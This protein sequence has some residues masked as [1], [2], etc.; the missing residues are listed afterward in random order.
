MYWFNKDEL[1]YYNRNQAGYCYCDIIVKPQDL[2]LQAFMP[3]V[4]S[5]VAYTIKAYTPDGVT[6]LLDLAPF[7]KGLFAIDNTGRT[8]CTFELQ[9]FPSS[10]CNEC[11]LVRFTVTDLVGGVN[12]VLFDRYTQ[13]YCIKDCCTI[14]GDLTAS[15]DFEQETFTFSNGATSYIDECGKPIVRIESTFPCIDKYT[16]D[17]YGAP[18]VKIK[19]INNDA[20]DNVPYRK[21]SNHYALWKRLPREINTT[22]ALNCITQKTE[23]AKLYMLQSSQPVPMWKMEELENMLSS[24]NILVNGVQY[25]LQ[26][27]TPFE[28]I[29]PY[30]INAVR[31]FYRF[32]I[33]L[34]SCRV[35]QIFGCAPICKVSNNLKY[36]PIT[37]EPSYFYDPNGVL[38]AN[39]TDEFITYLLSL[40][41]VD[42]VQD[43]SYAYLAF[44]YNTVL[45][46]ETTSGYIPSFF[47]INGRG[48][49][50]KVFTTDEVIDLN[51]GCA[52]A[53]IGVITDQ[54]GACPAA[55][56][57]T[58]AD[59]AQSQLTDTVYPI[60]QW[61]IEPGAMTTLS[62]NWVRLYF[63]ARN[64]NLANSQNE[65]A[66]EIVGFVLPQFA[67]SE[68][69]VIVDNLPAN[70]TITVA[71]DGT[72]RWY[73]PLTSSTVSYGE[74]E[75]LSTQ[76][77]NYLI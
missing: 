5:A 77:I 62:G 23:G 41:D 42:N 17:Y 31:E 60:N 26:T 4:T 49:E 44:G 58:I 47:Y 27:S 45:Q 21:I 48:E 43:V 76:E 18:S 53:V 35:W 9:S 14:I 65:L 28:R 30:Q 56:F 67:P 16:G 34:R 75:I 2:I 64:V 8:Y 66:A 37:T 70:T 19:G 25:Q 33:M 74:V 72:I 59:A 3:S 73:G 11:F 32:E 71:T 39:T 24:N 29:R 50:Y 57:G 15:D 12:R 7:V 69:R 22:I 46:V 40:P 54:D 51:I 36:V 13:E 61:T 63:T 55:T 6:E 20:L 10:L 1:L 68:Q 52:K 38:I